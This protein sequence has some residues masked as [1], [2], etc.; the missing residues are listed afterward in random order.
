M[1]TLLMPSRQ[2]PSTFETRTNLLLNEF[3]N[4][5]EELNTISEQIN[6]AGSS[7]QTYIDE[8]AEE[9]ASLKEQAESYKGNKI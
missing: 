3:P 6:D 2:D 7:I 1:L 8:V 4:F 9:V 5:G